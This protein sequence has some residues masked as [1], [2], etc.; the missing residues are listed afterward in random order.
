MNAH[1]VVRLLHDVGAAT[2]FGGS[3]MG[4]I[5]LNGAASQLDDPVQRAR[6][7]TA[8]WSRWAPVAG[9]GVASHLVGSAGLT[10]TDWPRVRMQQ[11][12]GRASL[13]KTVL[14]V[15]GVGVS[16]WSA[17]LNRQMAAAGPVPVE[18]STEPGPMTPEGVRVTQQQLK[19][20]QWA[21]PLVAGSIIGVASWMSEQQRTDQVVPG[22]LKGVAGGLSQRLPVVLPAAAAVAFGAAAARRQRRRKSSHVAAYPAPALTVGP[23]AT[24]TTTYASDGTS[25]TG[26]PPVA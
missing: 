5:G 24:T 21:N 13:I 15:A 4:A 1:P 17:A 16:V 14:T 23:P 19:I 2:W 6:A 7:S 22:V 25:S 12:V 26:V 8:G 18:G 20:S 9:A 10:L 3:L 11:G